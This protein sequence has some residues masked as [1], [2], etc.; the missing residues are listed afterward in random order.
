MARYFRGRATRIRGRNDNAEGEQGEVENR[1]AGRV[2]GEDEGRV[3]PGEA[4]SAVE[5]GGKG[6]GEGY[7]F[8]VGNA[9]AAG[10]VDEGGW[11]GGWR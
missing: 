11:R 4:E 8:V 1:D 6:F 7:Q 9:A 5:G 3:A 2:G 10:D